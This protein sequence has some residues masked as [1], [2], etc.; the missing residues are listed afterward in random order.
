MKL[1]H[2]GHLSSILILHNC[3]RYQL[4][5]SCWHSEPQA[6]LTFTQL[7]YSFK[8]IVAASNTDESYITVQPDICPISVVMSDTALGSSHNLTA[9]GYERLSTAL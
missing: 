3:T 4:M 9:V 8:S 7:Q 1:I 5:L 2:L 6:R